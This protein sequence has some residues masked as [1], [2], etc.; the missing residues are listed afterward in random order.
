MR[1]AWLRS[2][3]LLGGLLVLAGCSESPRQLLQ[4]IDDGKAAEALQ[5]LE[6]RLADTP[7]D[8]V[9]TLLAA[10]ARLQACAQRQCATQAV[11]P[12]ILDPIARLLQAAPE[13][14]ALGTGD[15][16]IMLRKAEVLASATLAF[17]Q[18]PSQPGALLALRA[19]LPSALQA[20]Q[21]PSL[22][23]AALTP[24][25]QGAVSPTATMLQALADTPTLPLGFRY[26]ADLLLALLRDDLTQQAAMLAALRAEPALAA[27]AQ[28][29]MSLL[30]HLL[31]AGSPNTPALL[32][33]LP[34]WFEVSG[35]L[36]PLANAVQAQAAATELAKLAAT[37]AWLGPWQEGWNIATSGPLPL[38][39]QRASLR[40][41]PNQPSVWQQYLP[42]LVAAA[43]SHTTLPEF[44]TPFSA[45]RLTGPSAAQLGQALLGAARGL[46]NRPDLAAPLLQ[47]ASQLGLPSP[48]QAELDR[49]TQTLLIKAANARDVTATLAL[50]QARPQAATNN[51]QLV[52][53]LLVESIRTDL[54]DGAFA[55]A[56]SLTAFI[57]DTLELPLDLEPLVIEEFQ[58]AMQVN[59]IGDKLSATSPT[60]LLQPRETVAL[61]LGPLW[62]F[63][64][65]LFADQPA[66]LRG[67]LEGLVASARGV[68]GPPTAMYRLLGLFPEDDQP[69]MTTWL[70]SAMTGAL[71]QDTSL[72][73]AALAALAGQLANV[74]D[75]LSL[76]PVLEAALGRVQNLDESRMLW[77]E[78]TVPLRQLMRAIR[79]Q[80]AA[81]MRAMDAQDQN[82]PDVMADNLNQLTESHWLDQ[83]APLFQALQTSLAAVGGV[84]VPLSAAP[85][86][87][88]AALFIT[89]QGLAGGDLQSINL[90]LLN[91]LGTLAS[92]DPATLVTTP[93]VMQRLT[94]TGPYRFTSNELVLTPAVVASSPGGGSMAQRYGPLAR[95]TFRPTST[96]TLL[97]ATL[98]DGTTLQLGRLLTDPSTPL[99][100]DG[101]YALTTPLEQTLTAQ[102]AEARQILPPGSILTLQTAPTTQPAGPEFGFSGPVYPL[103]GTLQHPARST[104]IS[105][106][107]EYDPTTLSSAFAF[108]YPLPGSGQT[109]R[110]AVKCQTLGGP[111]TCGAHHLHSPRLAYATL[112]RGLQTQESLQASSMERDRANAKART[113]LLAGAEQAIAK[114]VKATLSLAVSASVVVTSETQPTSLGAGAVTS[115]T[116]LTISPTHLGASPTEPAIPAGVFIRR[117]KVVSVTAVTAT[118]PVTSPT[119]PSA[120]AP[121]DD[122]EPHVGQ[123]V[124]PD[125]VATPR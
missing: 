14:V 66:V 61:N 47:L 90:T 54:R 122:A 17:A 81:L 5:T 105:F 23:Q 38:A 73:G 77:R 8:P 7:A 103:L 45:E 41:N 10:H 92:T 53:P 87:S 56:V 107:G 9:L 114:R 110:A 22:W 36:G 20:A 49:L 98:N 100:P 62:G 112:T 113:T 32:A 59:N 71:Q 31:R 120:T 111:I 82:Q 15:D 46:Q 30:P 115:V 35:T 3:G 121:H 93:A 11:P 57:N 118:L 1:T 91:R 88:L 44:A 24:A 12:A 119:S 60:L 76:A 13:A 94:L 108:S 40:L 78:A 63:M 50:A 39:L 26:T 29:A 6:A 109:V 75:G 85:D 99:M 37:P 83:A 25:R 55:R 52:V 72:N 2:I 84:Y 89:P 43:Q 65:D 124:E 101:D 19:S 116:A 79:P 21:T 74:H 64:T 18:L 48:Q 27:E 34:G 97:T 4:Q 95:L 80:Y 16:A 42:A 96:T 106:T 125:P 123:A 67:Q 33:T 104:P 102:P 117:G 86:I 58:T 70:H 28:G 51:R 69:A 68:Y